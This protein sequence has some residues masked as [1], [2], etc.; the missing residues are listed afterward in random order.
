MAWTVYETENCVGEINLYWPMERHV[1]THFLEIN[2]IRFECG[3]FLFCHA[4]PFIFRS[5]FCKTRGIIFFSYKGVYFVT[6]SA[7]TS[8]R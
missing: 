4:L 3:C 1:T 7:V 2:M 6:Y 8:E 5:E